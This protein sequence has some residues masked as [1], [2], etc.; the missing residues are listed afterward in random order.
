MLCVL[1]LQDAGGE[2]IFLQLK[3]PYLASY[4]VL[5]STNINPITNKNIYINVNYYTVYC[6]VG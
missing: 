1:A 5:I 4:K 6:S 3:P 2:V